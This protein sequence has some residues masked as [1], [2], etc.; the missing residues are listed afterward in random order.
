MAESC[1]PDYLPRAYSANS[2]NTAGNGGITCPMETLSFFRTSDE[3]EA[4]QY[5]LIIESHKEAQDPS[6]IASPRED[7]K[8]QQ[9]VGINK[10]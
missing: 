7:S 1:M 9:F 6:T 8:T 3:Y 10:S 5:Y 2:V 4:A